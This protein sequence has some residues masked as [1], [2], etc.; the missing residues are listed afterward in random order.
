[1][2]KAR[3]L[4]ELQIAGIPVPEF[5][6][7]RHGSSQ[8]DHRM[9]KKFVASRRSD[10]RFAVRS[11]AECEDGKEHSFAGI[12]D[13]LINVPRYAVPVAVAQVIASCRGD[14][15]LAYARDRG[16]DPLAFTMNV[17]IQD[18]VATDLSGVAFT[19]DPRDGAHVFLIECAYGLGELVVS[20]RTEVDRIVVAPCGIRMLNYKVGFQRE[21]LVCAGQ[22]V[23]TASL[24]VL[25]QSR[26]KLPTSKIPQLCEQLVRIEAVIGAPAD[27]EWGFFRQELFIFQARPLTTIPGPGNKSIGSDPASDRQGTT[28]CAD[29]SVL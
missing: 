11:S 14:R 20:G 16:L 29:S 25:D 21:R 26:R 9:A 23:V 24:P 27:V 12:F 3:R 6:V 17:V 28:L 18:F 4:E 8:Q 22:G 19:R 1:M 13:S 10:A 7:I 15:A 2:S 5:V